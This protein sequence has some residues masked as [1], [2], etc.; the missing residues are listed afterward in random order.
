MART[1]RANSPKHKILEALS[2]T[3]KTAVELAKLIGQAHSECLAILEDL[4]SIGFVSKEH[5]AYTVTMF[6]IDEYSM[7]GKVKVAERKK[8]E[9]ARTRDFAPMGNLKDVY[10]L[11]LKRITQRDGALDFLNY[12]SVYGGQRKERE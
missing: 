10:N 7:L 5:G 12:P 3:N 4:M 6:G 1:I 2:S 9:K 8:G 11:D